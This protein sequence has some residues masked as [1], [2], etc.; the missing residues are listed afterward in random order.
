MAA[1]AAVVVHMVDMVAVVHL[2]VVVVH[3]AAAVVVVYMVVDCDSNF[4]QI[5]TAGYCSNCL[6]I[7]VPA[8][9]EVEVAAD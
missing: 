5:D 7:D 6:Q 2:A 1:A 9:V 4:L 8:V 3:M